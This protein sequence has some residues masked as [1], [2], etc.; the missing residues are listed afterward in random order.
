MNSEPADDCRPVPPALDAAL[1]ALDRALKAE[2]GQLPA[3]VRANLPPI[4][5]FD[6]FERDILLMLRRPDVPRP[7]TPCQL[8]VLEGRD[9]VACDDLLVWLHW[10]EE[11][12]S[13]SLVAAS[14]LGLARVRTRF[15]G[16]GQAIDGQPELFET[17]AEGGKL[18]GLFKRYGTWERAEEGHQWVVGAAG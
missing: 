15:V 3:S 8:Y 18:D 12:P 4:P 11:N 13:A 5:S 1:R 7:T 9:P 14:D 10:F 6:E 17:R 2:L 16:A